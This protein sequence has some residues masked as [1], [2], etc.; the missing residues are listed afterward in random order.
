MAWA[1]IT[2]VWIGTLSGI[3][4]P[5]MRLA[6]RLLLM[7]IVV[8]WTTIRHEAS[9][10]AAALYQGAEIKTINLLPG[11]HAELGFYFGYV[12]HTGNVTW[13]TASA[14]FLADILLLILGFILLWKITHENHWFIYIVIFAI[15]SPLADL[16]Y[17]YQSG[18]W[19]K[20]TDV[21]NL[22]QEIANWSVHLFFLILITLGLLLLQ[23]ANHHRRS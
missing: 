8:L 16:I 14:P 4:S 17:A 19:R 2:G 6:S 15:I 21:A 12:E 13:L 9:H 20:G 11:I 1:D 7:V 18:L 5:L 3:A 10:A 22:F 23:Y